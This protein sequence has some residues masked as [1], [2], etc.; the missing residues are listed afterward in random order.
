M[1]QNLKPQVNNGQAK[2]FTEFSKPA[3]SR[4]EIHRHCLYQPAMKLIRN[5]RVTIGPL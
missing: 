3:H 5:K 1:R 4:L 2:L